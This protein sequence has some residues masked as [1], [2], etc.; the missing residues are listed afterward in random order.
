M[1]D[2]ITAEQVARAIEAARSDEGGISDALGGWQ[3]DKR[4]PDYVR[5]AWGKPSL[6]DFIAALTR[7]HAEL[8]AA[9]T[10]RKAPDDTAPER[11]RE[12]R[13]ALGWNQTW[14]AEDINRL[15]GFTE[16]PWGWRCVASCEE[17]SA[18]AIDRARYAAALSAAEAERAAKPDPL[19]YADSPAWD[20]GPMPKPERAPEVVDVP[21]PET[22]HAR[23]VRLAT[24]A[25]AAGKACAEAEAAF[26][27]ADAVRETA[28]L[29]RAAARET[30]HVKRQALTA[31]TT[32]A[33]IIRDA[34]QPAPVQPTRPEPRY[35]VGDWVRVEGTGT[36]YQIGEIAGEYFRKMPGS[37][38]VSYKLCA[39]TPAIDPALHETA[40]KTVA[41]LRAGARGEPPSRYYNLPGHGAYVADVRD[42]DNARWAAQLERLL[43]DAP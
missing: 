26:T 29:V 4:A 43:G 9:E 32:A 31:A 16:D 40:R 3:W 15:H 8:V 19:A 5:V 12:R 22:W 33:A 11:L 18:S 25:Q 42:D 30:C 28:R 21:Q 41:W 10:P 27:R 13:E 1:A 14:A 35:K 37:A 2:P 17:G 20:D 7:W 36:V 34:Q 23:L 6:P 39:L 24:E 38:S